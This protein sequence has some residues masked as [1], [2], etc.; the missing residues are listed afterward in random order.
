VL[1]VLE[2]SNRW[3]HDCNAG[4]SKHDLLLTCVIKQSWDLSLHTACSV[5]Q[6][7]VDN[8]MFMGDGGHHSLDVSR[9]C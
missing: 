2:D 5:T 3:L 4:L 7:A 8:R 6:V 1:A 9:G